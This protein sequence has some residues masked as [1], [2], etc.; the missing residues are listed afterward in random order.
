MKK[1]RRRYIKEDKNEVG[2]V[3]GERAMPKRR[4]VG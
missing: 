3:D 1:K 2:N 4:E